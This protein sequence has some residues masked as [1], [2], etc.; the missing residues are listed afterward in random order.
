MPPQRR[1]QIQ[2]ESKLEKISRPQL[3]VF[4]TLVKCGVRTLKIRLNPEGIANVRP[5]ASPHISQP[6][7]TVAIRIREVGDPQSQPA[8]LLSVPGISDA[9]LKAAVDQQLEKTPGPETPAVLQEH[10]TLPGGTPHQLPEKAWRFISLPPQEIDP[11]HRQILTPL[12][13]FVVALGPRRPELYD[14]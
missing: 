2:K 9:R 4:P 8:Q 11:L 7:R 1:L 3:K 5:G 6:A 10:F 14:L 13:S 12:E